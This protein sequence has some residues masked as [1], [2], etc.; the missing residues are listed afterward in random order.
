MIIVVVLISLSACGKSTQTTWQE[1]YDLGVRYLSEGTYEEAIIAFTAAIE[2]D[3]KRPEAYVSRGDAYIGSGETGENLACAMTDYEEAL[4][5]DE[6]LVDAWLGLTDVY[7]RQGDYDK[8]LEILREALEKTGENPRIADKL[9]EMESGSFLDSAGNIRRM[10]AYDSDGN[11]KWYHEFIYNNMGRKIAVRSYFSTGTQSNEVILEYDQNGNELVDYRYSA[12]DGIV[13]RAENVWDEQG[14]CVKT[15]LYDTNGVL[16]E[17]YIYTYNQRREQIKDERYSADG[18][19]EYYRLHEYDSRG[20]CSKIS[21]FLYDD[22]PWGY[23]LYT[24]DQENRLIQYQW[25]DP[26]GELQGSTEYRYDE[27]GNRIGM[28]T[29]AA[30]G[31]FISSTSF[32]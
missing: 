32:G 6:S 20:N 5:I 10:N 7:I 18:E 29:Y 23:S 27:E 25:Y 4:A 14:N 19:L 16:T 13:F 24:Y 3:P 1:Q 9:E 11:L 21:E 12:D 17:Y 31:V 8:A 2:I 22:T 15:L 28:E 26:G 30:D